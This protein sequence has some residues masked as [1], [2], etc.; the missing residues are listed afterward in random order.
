[1]LLGLQGKFYRDMLAVRDLSTDVVPQQLTNAS[2][3]GGYAI[4]SV[5]ELQQPAAVLWSGGVAQ[6]CAGCCCGPIQVAPTLSCF[7]P[8]FLAP[9]N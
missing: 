6:T 1:M 9:S 8:T 3:T 7:P 4:V 2:Y 5:V